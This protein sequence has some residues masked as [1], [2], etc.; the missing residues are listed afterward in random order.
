MFDDLRPA[1]LMVAL[2]TVL[3]GFAYP[4][5]VT[6]VA[7]AFLP[8]QANGSLVEIEGRVAGSALVDKEFAAERYFWPRPS[9]AGTDGYDAAASSGSNLGPTSKAL[10]KRIRRV[11]RGLEVAPVA[12]DAVTASASGLDPHISPENARAQVSRVAAARGLD[13]GAV[14]YLVGQNTEHR[15]AGF[16][17][18]PRVNVLRMNIALDGLTPRQ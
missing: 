9:A 10:M 17:G 18:E 6:A 14:L 11:S 8:R 7:Q 2:F 5:F 1:L 12:A 4:L 15:F 16:L 3:T 13:Q